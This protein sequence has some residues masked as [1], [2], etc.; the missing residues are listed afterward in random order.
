MAACRFGNQNHIPGAVLVA[1]SAET[2]LPVNNLGEQL[3]S[4]V[5]RGREGHNVVSGFG[6]RV[7][8]NDGSDK[9]AVLIVGNY[10]TPALY[11]AMIQQALLDAGLAD[12]TCTYNST[13]GK[14][15][16]G[17]SGAFSLPWSTGANA[18]R[19]AGKDMGFDT[20]ADDAS[21]A[22]HTGDV[23]SYHSREWVVADLGTAQAMTLCAAIDGNF[24]ETAVVTLQLN[25]SD[26][27]SAPAQEVVLNLG[28]VSVEYFAEQTYRYARLLIEDVSNEDGYSEVGVWYLGTYLEP[29]KNFL[30]GFQL[31][32]EDLSVVST[33]VMGSHFTDLKPQ[34]NV[35][36]LSWPP[37]DP[38]IRDA[39]WGIWQVL[40]VGS[41]FVFTLEPGEYEEETYWAFLPQ[42]PRRTSLENNLWSVEMTISEALG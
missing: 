26:S 20:S 41:C 19:S 9:V 32:P 30:D 29:D 3:R 42:A 17:S 15:T 36:S 10:T 6:D 38:T 4:Q 33:G 12:G 25:S 31:N 34:R 39:L 35:W 5:W 21:A 28:E 13:T 23:A 18:A 27:W 24:S 8:F 7:D 11:V 1:S 16:L 40:P 37:V 2:A 22:S 14:I